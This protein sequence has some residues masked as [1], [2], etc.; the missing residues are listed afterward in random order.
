[1]F[2]IARSSATN[3][4]NDRAAEKRFEGGIGIGDESVRRERER[5]GWEGRERQVYRERVN[6]CPGMAERPPLTRRRA[7]INVYAKNFL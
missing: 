3:G 4:A 1:M 7:V 5:M 2:F 6:A